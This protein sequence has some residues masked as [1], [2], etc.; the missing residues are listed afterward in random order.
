MKKNILFLFL[1][2]VAA[3]CAKL[4]TGPTQSIPA[5]EA[6]QTQSDL[7]QALNGC[8]DALQLPGFYGRHTVLAAELSSDNANA[9]GTILEYYNISLNN[10]LSNNTIAESIWNACYIAI[11]RVNNVLYY[12][13]N[14]ENISDAD[15][16]NITGQLY[17]IRSLAY[18]NLVRYFGDT[19][20]KV[21]PTLST[22]DLDTP[23]SSM[24]DVLTHIVGDLEFA[25]QNIGNTASGKASSVA[26]QA[27]LAKIA[28]Y[29]LRWAD[30]ESYANAV[31]NNTN[32]SLVADYSSLFNSENNTESIFEVQYNDQDKNRMAE[33]CFPSSLGGRYEV[34][35]T[36]DLINLFTAEDTR[37]NASFDGFSDKPYSIKYWQISSGADRVYVFRLAEMYLIRAE[38]RIRQQ[39]AFDGI[40][41][42]INAIRER[43]MLEPVD[44]QD[45]DALL[46]EML[47]QRQLE[48]TF[49][50]QRWFD[51]IRSN[52][53]LQT[54]PTV[55]SSDQLLFPIPFA[56]INTNSAIGP[57]NQ[58]PGY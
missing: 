7:N 13:P 3:S 50:G 9:T 1:I 22:D 39:S 2:F 29:D 17:F 8:Y 55:N 18:F 16:N 20:L 42:D 48:F 4:D 35:P 47:Q 43:A 52:L 11:N 15:K 21:T 26:A 51:L 44:L 41:A 32:Y 24:A 27:L 54:L 56:E 12:L 37:L 31:I 10:L 34:S 19:P 36:E 58:N 6:I 45:Y 23:R 25:S 28:L 38:A 53:A 46:Q 57:E 40:N 14:V 33:Y 30:A 49:E 5:N